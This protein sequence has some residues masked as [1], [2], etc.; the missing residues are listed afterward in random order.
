MIKAKNE[1][2]YLLFLGILLINPTILPM[3]DSGIN[4]N[5]T[6][7][8]KLTLLQLDDLRNNS[9]IKKKLQEKITE[10]IIKRI[11][12]TDHVNDWND[13]FHNPQLNYATV[14]FERL[15]HF[16]SVIRYRLEWKISETSGEII[17][18]A[19]ERLR[20][21]NQAKQLYK[22]AEAKK[23]EKIAQQSS[24]QPRVPTHQHPGFNHKPSSSF[25]RFIKSLFGLGAGLSL[26]G[27]GLYTYL[28]G[29]L[30]FADENTP[31]ATKM[32]AGCFDMGI[33]V[34][35]YFGSELRKQ[36]QGK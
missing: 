1:K 7:L 15:L 30:P 32:A 27:I 20:L 2:L 6:D 33:P 5:T 11:G 14:P 25:F 36:Y 17:T 12:Q 4:L 16:E 8:S 28:N 19:Q 21:I 23:T 10:E 35:I 31:H 22:E 34:S 3:G 24:S 18:E 13:Q 26:G 29:K 9:S